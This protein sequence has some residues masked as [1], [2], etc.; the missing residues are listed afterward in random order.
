M[1]RI[2][3]MVP[4]QVTTGWPSGG[5]RDRGEGRLSERRSTARFDPEPH[6]QEGEAPEARVGKLKDK[7][8]SLDP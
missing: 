3:Q 7:I 8:A 6:R 2:Q 1:V 4:D 5:V